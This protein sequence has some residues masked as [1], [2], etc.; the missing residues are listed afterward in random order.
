MV[1]SPA[2]PSAVRDPEGSIYL[3]TKGADTVIFERLRKKG[4]MEWTTEDILAVSPCGT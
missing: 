1:G 4:V 2:S 3:Y